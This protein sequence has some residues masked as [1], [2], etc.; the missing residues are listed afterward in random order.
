MLETDPSLLGGDTL[1]TLEELVASIRADGGLVP[2]EV[3]PHKTGTS[4]EG[5]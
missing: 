3:L 1:A 4:E 5:G 2:L